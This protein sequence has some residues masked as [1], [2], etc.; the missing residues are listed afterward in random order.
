MNDTEQVLSPTANA[1]IASHHQEKASTL[2][3][4][5]K[6]RDTSKDVD[7]SPHIE[8]RKSSKTWH[9]FSQFWLIFSMFWI[10]FFSFSFLEFQD[11][12]ARFF[13]RVYFADDFVKLRSKIFPHGEDR[14]LLYFYLKLFTVI[15]LLKTWKYQLVFVVDTF[16]HCL[17]ASRGWRREAKVGQSSAKRKT[18]ASFWSKCRSRKSRVSSS[19]RRTCSNTSLPLRRSRF[20]GR[21]TNFELHHWTLSSCSYFF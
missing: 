13:C 2:P 21:F 8:L 7:L 12:S 10:I 9:K 5:S 19:L 3:N 20:P 15:N 14:W 11:S 1:S 17:A 4:D 16:A 18:T 6:L